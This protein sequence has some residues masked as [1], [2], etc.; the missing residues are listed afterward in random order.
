MSSNQQET[1]SQPQSNEQKERPNETGEENQRGRERR[2]RGRN[3]KRGGGGGYYKVVYVVKGQ[4]G[5]HDNQHSE[6]ERHEENQ[7]ERGGRRRRRRGGR[8][9]RNQ[10]GREGQEERPRQ[11]Q[12]NHTETKGEPSERKGESHRQNPRGKKVNSKYISLNRFENT[13]DCHLVILKNLANYRDQV[14]V[15]G[16]G[17]RIEDLL[18]LHLD[19]SKYYKL[20]RLSKAGRARLR[21]SFVRQ[22]DFYHNIR[23]DYEEVF[24]RERP[25]LLGDNFRQQEVSSLLIRNVRVAVVRGNVAFEDSDLIGKAFFLKALFFFFF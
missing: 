15:F 10:R 22:D 25:I 4:E 6:T 19:Y 18:S 8:R 14:E 21:L 2:G 24:R 23:K 3:P 13:E 5:V 7:E 12:D 9:N 16:S 17:G 11:P 20:V 1:P